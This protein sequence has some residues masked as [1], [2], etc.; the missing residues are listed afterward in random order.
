MGMYDESWCNSCGTSIPYTEK[1]DYEAYCGWSTIRKSPL[2]LIDV[3]TDQFTQFLKDNIPT[4]LVIDYV[5][6][7]VNGPRPDMVTEALERVLDAGVKFKSVTFEH[8]IH[9]G[10]DETLNDSRRILEELGF[11][12]LAADVRLWGIQFSNPTTQS[13]EDWWI[14]PQYFDPK[15]L[16][17]ATS[18]LYYFDVIETIKNNRANSYTVQHHCNRA[19]PDEYDTFWHDGNRQELVSWFN[20]LNSQ[21]NLSK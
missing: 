6:L 1:E 11:V 20:Q 9:V 7:D 19:Y 18:N 21:L 14:D 15:L 3:T 12:K 17:A 4:D 8:E 2:H 16:E 10:Y 5:S 13:F